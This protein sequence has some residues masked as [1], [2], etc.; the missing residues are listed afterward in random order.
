MKLCS[1]AKD[2]VLELVDFPTDEEKL[3]NSSTTVLSSLL[4][5][6]GVTDFLVRQRRIAFQ[7]W[8]LTNLF[9]A[10]LLPFLLGV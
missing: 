9:S 3:L 1:A 10:A 5:T 4:D 7:I 6:F 8:S 2:S